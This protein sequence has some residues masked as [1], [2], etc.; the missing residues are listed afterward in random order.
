MLGKKKDLL[1]ER[2]GSPRGGK[3]LREECVFIHYQKKKVTWGASEIRFPNGLEET[4]VNVEDFKGQLGMGSKY[5]R[6]WKSLGS[7]PPSRVLK[8]VPIHKVLALWQDKFR[9]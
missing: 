2:E 3:R 9:S 8:S 4:V 5:L 7:A 1:G 6:T